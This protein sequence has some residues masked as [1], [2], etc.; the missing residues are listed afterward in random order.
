MAAQRR[1]GKRYCSEW[2]GTNQRRTSRRARA[3]GG[4]D[5]RLALHLAHIAEG[6]RIRRV[7]DSDHCTGDWRQLDRIQRARRPIGETAAV[8]R[9]RQAG[10]DRESDEDGRRFVGSYVAGG[11]VSRFSATKYFVRG[12]RGVLRLLWGG[13]Q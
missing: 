4:H 10:M 7:C 1:G 9:A 12:R 2:T 5:A 6:E 11:A 3:G 8:Q 13:R